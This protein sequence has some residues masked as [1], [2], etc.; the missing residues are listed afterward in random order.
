ML[1]SQEIRNLEIYVTIEQHVNLGINS[2]GVCHTL[3]WQP[4]ILFGAKNINKGE[5]DYF[6]LSFY[7][8]NIWGVSRL[9]EK[10]NL[11]S[12]MP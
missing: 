5:G 12:L 1:K 4:K 8:Q 11:K 7:N 6:S 10:S 9:S 2:I 3:S